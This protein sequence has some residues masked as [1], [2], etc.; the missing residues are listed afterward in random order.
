VVE[1]CED[2]AAACTFGHLVATR[3]ILDGARAAARLYPAVDAVRSHGRPPDEAHRRVTEAAAELLVRYAEVD[4]ELR[5]DP[6]DEPWGRAAQQLHRYLAQ[7]FHT[8]ELFTGR[9]GQSTA[10]ADAVSDVE[11]ILAGDELDAA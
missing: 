5:L 4:P 6:S 7:P 1:R 8:T 3:V 10:R 11:G 2:M 9:V